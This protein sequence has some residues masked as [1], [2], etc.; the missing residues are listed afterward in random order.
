MLGVSFG[1]EL[2]LFHRQGKI[3]LLVR[4]SVDTFKVKREQVFEES[5]RFNVVCVC[6]G[7]CV[8]VCVWVCLCVWGCVRVRV[9]VCGCVSVCVREREEGQDAL[10]NVFISIWLATNKWP[11]KMAAC[12]I[13][14]TCSEGINQTLEWLA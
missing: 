9:C 5:G 8:F 12:D 1:L 14:L 13:T 3:L 2:I 10:G 4:I 11:Q 7:V 6:V